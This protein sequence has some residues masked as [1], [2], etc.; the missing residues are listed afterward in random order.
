MPRI[1]DDSWRTQYFVNFNHAV[2]DFSL[3]PVVQRTPSGPIQAIDGFSKPKDGSEFIRSPRP[4]RPR[5][6][7]AKISSLQTR[8]SNESLNLCVLSKPNDGVVNGKNRRRFPDPCQDRS[9]LLALFDPEQNLIRLSYVDEAESMS[10]DDGTDKDIWEFSPQYFIKLEKVERTLI[11]AETYQS[12]CFDPIEKFLMFAKLT[13]HTV[14][15]KCLPDGVSG[16]WI[17]TF[18]PPCLFKLT[19]SLWSINPNCKALMSTKKESK[20]TVTTLERVSEVKVEFKN[21]NRETKDTKMDNIEKV[22]SLVNNVDI[23]EEKDCIAIVSK[24]RYFRDNGKQKEFDDVCDKVLEKSKHRGD[25]D[26]QIVVMLEQSMY[27]C[28]QGNPSQAKRLLQ[29]VVQMCPKSE[30]STALLNRAYLYL[31]HIHIADG[32]YGTAQ[33]CLGMVKGRESKGIPAQDIAHYHVLQ[34]LIMTNFATKVKQMSQKLWLEAGNCFNKAIQFYTKA[35]DDT[36]SNVCLVQCHFV[37]L[38]VLMIRSEIQSESN[39]DLEDK[40]NDHMKMIESMA[41]KNL[42]ERTIIN[43]LISK[44]EFMLL[45]KRRTEALVLIEQAHKLVHTIRLFRLE[46]RELEKTRSKFYTENMECNSGD[47]L[48][49]SSDKALNLYCSEGESGYVAD[50]SSPDEPID[51]KREPSYKHTTYV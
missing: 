8:K 36:D 50:D 4:K 1:K 12:D 34:G 48:S 33:E 45:F 28:F 44:A 40:L 19:F 23:L 46:E 16:Y 6:S 15:D 22:E 41:S 25:L 7:R 5:F 3:M 27:H 10:A 43:G 21:V 38:Y 20:N 17:R 24:L 51:L 47:E 35:P 9:I 13:D 30:H 42:T 14:V 49:V 31:A 39:K 18:G 26:K 11:S 29:R 32:T 2:Q 37:K